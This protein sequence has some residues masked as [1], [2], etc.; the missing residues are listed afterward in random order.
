MGFAF[1]R[2][3]AVFAAIRREALTNH[4]PRINQALI[5]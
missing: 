1:R 4:E 3:Q 5:L 2:W